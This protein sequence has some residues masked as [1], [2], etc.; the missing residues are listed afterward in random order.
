MPE[1]SFWEDVFM[2]LRKF[3][4]ISKSEQ[5]SVFVRIILFPISST[6]MPKPVVSKTKSKSCV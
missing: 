6:K 4:L 3:T 5:N 1:N 2:R